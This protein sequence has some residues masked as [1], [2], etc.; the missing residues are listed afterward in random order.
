[1]RRPFSFVPCLGTD[2]LQRLP[3]GM[4]TLEVSRLVDSDI[5]VTAHAIKVVPH[6]P[7]PNAKEAKE[8]TQ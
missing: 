3:L 2:K 4:N 1:M 6:S 8:R 7:D 5:K